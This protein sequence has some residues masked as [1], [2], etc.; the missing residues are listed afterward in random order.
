LLWQTQQTLNSEQ[1]AQGCE[2]STGTFKGKKS[3][4]V[5]PIAIGIELVKNIS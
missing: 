2:S 3:P 5:V 4:I 1:N